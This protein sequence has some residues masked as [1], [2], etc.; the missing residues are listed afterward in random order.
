MGVS[1]VGVALARSSGVSVAT[2]AMVAS[3]AGAAWVSV[4]VGVT[5]STEACAPQAEVINTRKREI[6]C[7]FFLME[8]SYLSKKRQMKAI[9]LYTKNDAKTVFQK[10]GFCESTHKKNRI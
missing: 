10:T 1:G 7:N 5:A 3:V 4:S 6:A 9:S 2:I 8:T